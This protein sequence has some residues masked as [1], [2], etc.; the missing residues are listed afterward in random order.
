MRSRFM[1][2]AMKLHNRFHSSASSQVRIA[3]EFRGRACDYVAV[4]I[5][6]G[7]HCKALYAAL[8]AKTLGRARV[9]ALARPSA[10]SDCQA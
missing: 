8:S 10:C 5:A 4:Q 2:W 9:R 7:E 3:L 1:L 6:K